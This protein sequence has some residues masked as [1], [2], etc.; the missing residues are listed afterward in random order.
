MNKLKVEVFIYGNNTTFKRKPDKAQ[1][2]PKTA[3]V[4]PLLR[5]VF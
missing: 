5:R 4:E 2:P 3:V 1:S